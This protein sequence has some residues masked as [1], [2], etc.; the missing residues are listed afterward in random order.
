MVINSAQVVREVRDLIAAL[1]PRMPHVD[2]AG[3]AAYRVE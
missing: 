1:D 3:E 2:R